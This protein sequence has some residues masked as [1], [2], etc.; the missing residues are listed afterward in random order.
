MLLVLGYVLYGAFVETVFGAE[1][2]RRTPCYTMKDGVDYLEMPTWKVFL[3]QF[4]SLIHISE[5]TRPY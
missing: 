1:P 3:I 2:E 5:P 4:L